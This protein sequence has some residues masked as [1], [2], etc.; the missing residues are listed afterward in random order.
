MLAKFP[1]NVASC[2]S[3]GEYKASAKKILGFLFRTVI[4]NRLTISGKVGSA[5]LTRFCTSS[6]AILMSVPISKVTVMLLA[7]VQLLLLDIN[8]IP[9]VPLTCV[10]MAVVVVCSTVWASAPM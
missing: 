3:L 2:V 4:P 8:A 5:I 10:S 6:V 9:G 7:P 1:R